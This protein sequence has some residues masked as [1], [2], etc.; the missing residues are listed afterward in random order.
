MTSTHETWP[1]PRT[2]S[3]TYWRLLAIG[4]DPDRSKPELYGVIH[5]GKVDVPLMADGR[6]LF[7]TDPARAAAL[8]REYQ[9]DL[10][11]DKTD[12]EK[13][14]FWCDVA[15]TLHYLST[16]GIDTS[17]TVVDAVNVLLTLTSAAGAT[18]IDRRRQALNSIANYCTVN[19]DLTAYF[20]SEGDHSSREL[21]DAV[22]WCVGAV[23]AKARIV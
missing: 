9:R 21:I 13:P 8:V 12:L 22:L 10:V 18:M 3:E 23:V 2:G 14:F 1:R 15:Q 19:K 17:A 4:L 6:I 16:G 5:E 7:F 20:E 11:A